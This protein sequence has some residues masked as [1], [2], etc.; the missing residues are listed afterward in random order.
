MRNSS[1]D[2]LFNVMNDGR[3]TVCERWLE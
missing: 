2:N 3:V 1:Q